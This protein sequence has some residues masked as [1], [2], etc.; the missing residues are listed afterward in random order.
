MKFQTRYITLDDFKN[1]FQIDL[2]TQLGGEVHALGFLKRIE[3]RMESYINANFYKLIGK[4][5]ME[6]SDFQKEHYKLAL[7][8]QAIYIFKN[9][10]I[11][12]DSGYDPE[13][14]V[15]I[16]RS[17]LHILLIADNARM[18]LIECGLWNRHIGPVGFFGFW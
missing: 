12:V 2:V 1:Y 6:F 7:L 16:E 14:G 4:E 11:S 13:Q 15:K 9:G 3:D 17:K 8:E 5:Y 18:H 10:D